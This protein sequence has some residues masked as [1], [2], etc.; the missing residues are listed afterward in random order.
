MDIRDGHC[1]VTGLGALVVLAS[2]SP[3]AVEPTIRGEPSFTSS[4]LGA[5][6][7]S[8]I[9]ILE[10]RDLGT[11][12]VAPLGNSAA[13]G[14]N[15][16][17]D[18]VGWAI[19]ASGNDYAVRWREGAIAELG[20]LG[21]A[22]SEARDVNDAGTV[23]GIA[24]ST[25][26][27][28]PVTWAP[29]GAVAV[30]PEPD[31][32]QASTSFASDINE[33]GVVA[34]TTY[35][36]GSPTYAGSTHVMLWGGG[37]SVSLIDAPPGDLQ[38]VYTSWVGTN[39]Q[40]DIVGRSSGRAF[41]RRDSGDWED[42]GTLGGDSSHA[43]AINSSRVI[44]GWAM[45]GDG[46]KRAFIKP[47]GS[48]M[49]DIGALNDGESEAWAIN[50][51]GEVVGESSFLVDGRA[52]THGFYWSPTTGIVDLGAPSRFSYAR[53]I[54]E[55]GVI[56]GSAE[57]VPGTVHGYA[58]TYQCRRANAAPVIT[59]YTMPGAPLAVGTTAIASATFEDPDVADQHSGAV[60][61]GDG[62]GLQPAQVAEAGGTGTVQASRML[63]AA[64]VF[65]VTISVTDDSGATASVSPSA[66]LV[67]Y[68]PTAGFVAGAGW[69]HSPPGAFTSNPS[70]SGRASFGFLS[71]YRKGLQVPS[72]AARFEF[73]AASLRF[74]STSYDWLVS[75]PR[76]AQFKGEG[77]LNGVGGY[78]FLLTAMDGDAS[79]GEADRFRI[80]I[81][82]QATGT[83][84]Y[85]NKSGEPIQAWKGTEV[86]GGTIVISN[87]R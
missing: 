85:D 19:N 11:L 14:V 81:W 1:I 59:G 78:A 21:G 17:G 52:V 25:V 37:G 77:T 71:R 35:L 10:A 70:L 29:S 41:L 48:G 18:I 63:G 43:R 61:W 12:P 44:V 80:R 47:E 38:Q 5:S 56:V 7:P 42:L 2:C 26:R 50:E 16:S 27:Q 31:L 9:E 64:G 46:R 45:T 3:D 49:Q 57:P 22:H 75:Q 33:S 13:L 60:D 15:N 55:S 53:D 66:Y 72:G 4:A 73:A 87:G 74:R 79:A 23:V 86:R 36:S 8:G 39:L 58:W 76:R 84:E 34:G 69:I 30:L 6:C 68:D 67:V 65:G 40:G 32:G 62:S 20:T 82:N 54:N 24:Q 83:L 28:S 51:A